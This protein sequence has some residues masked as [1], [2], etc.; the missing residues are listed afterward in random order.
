MLVS[1]GDFTCL[2]EKKRSQSF[3]SSALYTADLHHLLRRGVYRQRKSKSWA[4]IT[5]LNF[6]GLWRTVNLLKW[7]APS[8][9]YSRYQVDQDSFYDPCRRSLCRRF[10]THRPDDESFRRRTNEVGRIRA[11]A[12]KVSEGFTEMRRRRRQVEW[13]IPTP[14]DTFGTGLEKG[15][16]P[17]QPPAD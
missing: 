3:H 5:A 15:Y 16:P 10:A 11:V 1:S 4:R 9:G 14:L 2:F 8:P 6:Q 13:G 12:R 17:L 7:S